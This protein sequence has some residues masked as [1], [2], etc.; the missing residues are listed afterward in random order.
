MLQD[1]PLIKSPLVDTEK[2]NPKPVWNSSIH[3]IISQ[4]SQSQN[5]LLSVGT[6]SKAL[7]LSFCSTLGCHEI[8]P[9]P[10]PLPLFISLKD[11]LKGQQNWNC[12]DPKKRIF[13]FWIETFF[14]LQVG[15]L[16]SSTGTDSLQR[17]QE[18][19][20]VF[21]VYKEALGGCQSQ[22]LC[23]LAQSRL[24]CT[25]AHSL[26]QL[27]QQRNCSPSADNAVI[28]ASSCHI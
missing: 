11:E 13:F 17:I 25:C 7:F 10:A 5:V 12:G 3:A 23:A 20:S 28:T 4:A 27:A 2:R 6:A 21:R 22:H 15:V 8:T 26:F 18:G 1:G 24:N 14:S 16:F 9:L 19:V